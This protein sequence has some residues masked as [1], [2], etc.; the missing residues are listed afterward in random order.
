MIICFI[1]YALIWY[2]LLKF[3]LSTNLFVNEFIILY[4]STNFSWNLKKLKLHINNLITTIHKTYILIT[5][6]KFF[7]IRNCDSSNSKEKKKKNNL[8]IR[9]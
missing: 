9:Y 1:K 8:V 2:I 6:I 5:L 7:K 3:Y 4:L